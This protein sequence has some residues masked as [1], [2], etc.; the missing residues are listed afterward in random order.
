M[1][2]PVLARA[3]AQVVAAQ[4]GVPAIKAFFD[5]PTAIVA[6]IVATH[7]TLALAVLASML[8][9]AAFAIRAVDVESRNRALD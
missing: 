3:S 7:V 5:T 2:D 1:S 9:A 8:V 6:P 4:K